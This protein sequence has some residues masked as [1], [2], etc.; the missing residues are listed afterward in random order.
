MSNDKI[1]GLKIIENM[2]KY[3]EIEINR[4]AFLDALFAIEVVD[5]DIENLLE[6]E[7]KLP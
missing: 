5:K 6:T 1:Q 7:G 2:I 4:E 3:A